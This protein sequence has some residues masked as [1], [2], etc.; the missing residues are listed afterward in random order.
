MIEALG[1]R[2]SPERGVRVGTSYP[3][4]KEALGPF[5]VPDQPEALV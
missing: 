3:D 1:P 5:C 2:S 4:R